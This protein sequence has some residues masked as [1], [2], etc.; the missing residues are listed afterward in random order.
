VPGESVPK[1]YLVLCALLFS[2]LL[3]FWPSL[4][5][6]FHLAAHDDRYLQVLVAPFLAAFLIFWDRRAI[7]RHA[8]Y[9][10]LTAILLALAALMGVVFR[11]RSLP[12]TISA[13]VLSV[14]GGFLLCFGV[15]SFRAAFYPLCCL[16]LMVPYPAA[17][18]DRIASSL[19]YGSADVSYGL[20]RLTGL[21]VFRH[22]L[23]FS[24]PGL[25]FQVGPECSGI[26]SSL[27]LLMVSLIAAYLYLRSGWS[28]AA[29]ILLTVPIALIKNAARIVVIAILGAYVDRIYVDGP[30]HHKYGG[31]VFSVFGGIL[32][33]L[34]LVGLQR[35]ERWLLTIGRNRPLTVTASMEPGIT[36][37]EY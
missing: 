28:R 12:L 19:Q 2:D 15:E 10:L 36:A 24:L 25:D 32:F 3:L 13:I 14:L 8:R 22:D 23:V 37:T 30:L 31:L 17:W 4:V 6:A 34:A 1:R 7:F 35:L 27:A 5:S 21:P 29:L 33:V 20:L 18:M 11:S 9:N 16:F 26:H